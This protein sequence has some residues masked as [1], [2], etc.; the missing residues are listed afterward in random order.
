MEV[1]KRDGR[2]VPVM[3]DKVTARIQK[4]CYGFDPKE[5]N[6]AKITKKVVAGIYDG[7]HVTA[8]DDL[9]AETAAF[10]STENPGY[11]RLAAR[12]AV[13]NLHK[14]TS[15]VFS[16]V[17][18]Q[19]Y[20]AKTNGRSSPLVSKELYDVVVANKEKLNAALLY[21]RDFEY[22]YFGYKTLEYA[23]LKKVEDKLTERPQHM[24]MR[25][26]LGIHGDDVDAAIQ[27]YDLMSQGFFTHAT[28]TM[29]NAGT[30]Q[31][32]MSSCFLLDIIDDSID[33][34]F[35]TL[36]RCALISKD[37]GGIGLSI[38]KIRAQG[39][40]IAGSGGSSNGVVPM[41]RTYDATARYVDQ[42]G[43]KRKGAFAA[44]CEPWHAD[45]F[46]FL[47][48]KKNHGK[49]EMRARDLFYALWVPDLFM[50]RV[51]EDGQ[52]SLFCPNEC[53]GMDDTWG[54][55][56]EKLYQGYEADGRARR[57]VSARALW[58]KVCESQIETGTPYMLYKDAAN[59]KS[60]QQNLGSIRCS[61]L[62]TEILEYTA[63]DEVAV[64]NLA[65]IA[66]PMMVDKTSRVFDFT[67]LHS[68]V[69]IVVRNLNRIIDR[70]HYPVEEAKYSNLRHRPIGVGVQ[71]L[72]DVFMLLRLPYESEE[73]QELN[74]D[75]FETIYYAALD[76]SCNLA[77]EEGAYE[78]FPGSP[79]S[80]GVLQFDMWDGA[81][82]SPRLALDWTRLRAR[83]VE[84]GLRNSLLV[85][86]MPTA[87]TAQILGNNEC[88]EPYT[89]NIYS[90]RVLAG[91]FFIVNRHLL[92]DLN[93]LGLWTPELCNE[94]IRNGGS[95]QSIEAIP[96]DLRA[97]YKTA[98]EMSSKTLIKMAA[99]RGA[100]IDQ[101]QSL[102]IFMRD[103]NYQ[104]LTAMHFYGWKSGL[105]TGMYY[106]RSTAASD[107][108]QFTV[109][110]TAVSNNKKARVTTC[111][112]EVCTTCSA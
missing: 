93:E 28:P 12:V 11:S 52:W 15:K 57:V 61:N 37:A 85:A 84:H 74:K 107:A 83:V 5:V 89:R 33:G 102:N 51:E 18:S 91:D 26:A 109:K 27:T 88:F 62:C 34:I 38:T 65:S 100:F 105:K 79:A 71:G 31:P 42:G 94:I 2:R 99:D 69:H 86:P 56:F 1:V 17:V 63:P 10:M 36:H 103:A 49:D 29:Y 45:I 73:A 66:L 23:Y 101:S 7:V 47:D 106:L 46:E 95:V 16:D 80:K 19:L 30:P 70:N 87:S 81:A 4:L 68:I 14:Q 55:A 78:T 67:L 98:L 43:G 21:N 97:L 64:C 112:D 50:R 3:F 22:D 53:P 48:L 54:E 24:L 110:P 41:L 32:Q 108:V 9:V 44:Y 104:K 92:R 13:S 60:N 75:I 8:I 90:R 111:T 20:E 39:S 6:P 58:Q 96:E 59:R 77:T 40:Y 82:P 35:R 25:V 72:A 76:A